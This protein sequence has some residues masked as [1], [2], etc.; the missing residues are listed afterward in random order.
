MNNASIYINR[1]GIALAI[2]VFI[3]FAWMVEDR[4]SNPA[5]EKDARAQE[6]SGTANGMI[7]A[8][9]QAAGSSVTVETRDMP[10][11][12]VWVAVQELRAGELSNVLGAARVLPNQEWVTVP[13]LRDTIAGVTYAVVLYRDDGDRSFDLYKDSIYVDFDSGER[14]VSLFKTL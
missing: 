8:N 2:V 1:I 6:T 5:V 3:I 7:H 9:S 13:L 11:A 4:L 10:E 12:D 14:V